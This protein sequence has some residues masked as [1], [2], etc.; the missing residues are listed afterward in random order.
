MFIFYDININ[1]TVYLIRHCQAMSNIGYTNIVDPP[2]TNLGRDQ[3]TTLKLSVDLL[4]CSPLRRALET[5]HHS[6]IEFKKHHITK[7]GRE[8]IYEPSDC[9]LLEKYYRESDHIFH[10]R[11]QNL[12][13]YMV[14][15]LS[16]NSTIALISHGCTIESLTGI[17]LDNGAVIEADL[18]L[19]KSIAKGHVIPVS[20]IWE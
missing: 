6:Q 15:K 14:S 8:L 4:I 5:A 13:L 20:P 10:N 9:L 18:D 17:R 1:M 12:A 7:L 16:A 3:A 19:L 2:L 11:I